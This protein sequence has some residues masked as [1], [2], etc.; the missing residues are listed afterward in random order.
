MPLLS[1]LARDMRLRKAAPFVTGDVLDL[2]CGNAAILQLCRN[3]IASYVG[4]EQNDASVA[5]LQHRFPGAEFHRRNLDTEPLDLARRFDVI[6]MLAV[7]E[8]IFNQR[9]LFTEAQRHLKPGGTIIVTTP[10][11]FGNDV[12]H[13]IGAAA[14]LFAKSAVDDHIVIYNRQRFVVLAKEIGLKLQRFELFEFG[15][16][17]LAVLA[18][19]TA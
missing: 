18:R 4:I 17:Q 9:H 1:N 3:R 7:I 11:Y 12:V 10:T 6:L 15:C 13:R 8:H 14:G 2:G 19:P 5:A 16:N